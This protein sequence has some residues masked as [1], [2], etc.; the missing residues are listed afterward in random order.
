MKTKSAD[1]F[2]RGGTDRRLGD[3]VR[4]GVR[5]CVFLASVMFITA[6]A[7]GSPL[8]FSGSLVVH[9][10]MNAGATDVSGNGLHGTISGAPDAVAGQYDGA[11]RFD[12]PVGSHSSGLPATEWITLA[13]LTSVRDVSAT[14]VVKY[15]TVDLNN[16]RLF[17]KAGA[18]L[19]NSWGGG[20]A[21]PF[22]NNAVSGVPYL[23]S[24]SAPDSSG[25]P[26][27]F[28][29]DG[30]WHWQMISID[31]VTDMVHYFFD[32]TL[33]DSD[34]IAVGSLPTLDNLRLGGVSGPGTTE[35]YAFVGDVDEF[36]VYSFA[37]DQVAATALVQA[38]PEAGTVGCAVVLCGAILARVWN[39]RRR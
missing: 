36:A 37:F 22:D 9:L 39:R 38:V 32:D 20:A 2:Q 33:V 18:V 8:P 28:L 25:N 34:P 11:L 12:N 30:N 14:Y 15:R 26:A 23:G 35:R 29:A 7:G 13:D 3:K 10:D 27:A 16:G 21:P 4:Q 17:G 5:G 1:V 31:R 24:G 6:S 19:M